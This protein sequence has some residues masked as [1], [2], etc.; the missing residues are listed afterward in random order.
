MGSGKTT[1]ARLLARQIG[2]HFVDLDHRIEQRAQLTIPE[3]FTRHGEPAFRE[4]EHDELVRILGEARDQRRATVLA[5][6]GGT[7]TQPANLEFLRETSAAMVW[8]DCSAEELL[9]RCAG[10]T[11]RPLFR[12]AA[13]FRQLYLERQPF[14]ALADFRVDSSADPARVVEQI[15]ALGIL[16][17]VPA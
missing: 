8:L 13:S 15:L 3:F 2:W 7:S 17:G 12:D 16:E 10:I 11:N 14:Y 6:G 9:G 4:L 5:L 1:V